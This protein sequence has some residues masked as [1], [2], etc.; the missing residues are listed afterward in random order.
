MAMIIKIP[1][2]LI[3]IIF[4]LLVAS[5]YVLYYFYRFFKP[6]PSKDIVQ[7]SKCIDNNHYKKIQSHKEQKH[8]FFKR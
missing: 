2:D 1:T 5:T 3:L 4:F 7:C 8:E 6:N